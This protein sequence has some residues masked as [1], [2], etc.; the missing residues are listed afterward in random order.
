MKL[1]LAIVQS[2]QWSDYWLDVREIVGWIPS[3]SN[4][5]FSSPKRLYQEVLGLLS[6]KVKRLGL[7]LTAYLH[8]GPR[9]K[10]NEVTPPLPQISSWHTQRQLQILVQLIPLLAIRVSYLPTCEIWADSWRKQA[11][12]MLSSWNDA[13]GFYLVRNISC[14]N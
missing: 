11:H 8:L 7:D 10:V 4:E 6:L 14:R 3:R 12:T 5:Y 1:W 2:F 13:L 9:L